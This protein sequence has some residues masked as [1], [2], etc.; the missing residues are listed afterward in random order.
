LINTSYLTIEPFNHWRRRY[1]KIE[2]EETWYKR[3]LWIG[4]HFALHCII[5][6][7]Y[8]C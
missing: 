7:N 2:K 6:H 4:E 3:F 5:A 8:S 1:D